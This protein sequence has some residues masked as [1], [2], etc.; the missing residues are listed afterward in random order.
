MNRSHNHQSAFQRIGLVCCLLSCANGAMAAEIIFV[1]DF[2]NSHPIQ[3]VQH[4]SAQFGSLDLSISSGP[5]SVTAARVCNQMGKF[6]L[7]MQ[8]PPGLNGNADYP[9]YSAIKVFGNCAVFAPNVGECIAIDGTIAEFNGATEL[10]N[11]SFT[12]LS[13]SDCGTPPVAYGGA[14]VADVASDSLPNTAGNQI[15]P[16]AEALESV[17]LKL[18]SVEVIT[19]NDFSGDFLVTAQSDLVGAR[20]V[21]GNNLYTY[22]A[23]PS[24]MLSSITGVLDQ[25]DVMPDTIFQLLPRD[26]SDIGP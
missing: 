17:L 9:D 7:W 21:V 12:Q 18:S 1:T 20:V 13:P 19:P 26:G 8:V 24:T 6:T 4:H 16:R 15:G 14:S 2:E 22:S 11:A 5:A 23:V 3:W 25:Q 10:T